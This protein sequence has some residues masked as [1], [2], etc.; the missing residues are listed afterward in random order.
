MELELWREKVAEGMFNMFETLQDELQ[1]T[2]QT[3]RMVI[4]NNKLGNL[5]LPTLHQQTFLYISVM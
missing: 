3:D 2:S 4:N 5:E 1:A